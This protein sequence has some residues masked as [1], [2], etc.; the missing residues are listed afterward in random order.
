MREVPFHPLYLMVADHLLTITQHYKE[1]HCFE[2]ADCGLVFKT[3]WARDVV[4]V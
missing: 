1:R 4:F 2:C 3:E